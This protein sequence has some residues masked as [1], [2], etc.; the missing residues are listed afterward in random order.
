MKLVIFLVGSKVHLTIL[1]SPSISPGTKQDDHSLATQG[2][3]IILTIGGLPGMR[4]QP[5]RH[6]YSVLATV[7]PIGTYSQSTTEVYISHKPTKKD[8]CQSWDGI[9][10]MLAEGNGTW[11]LKW[12][13]VA[14]LKSTHH[15]TGFEHVYQNKIY[16]IT[17]SK[18]QDSCIFFLP[19]YKSK[20]KPL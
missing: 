11:C 19:Q 4:P 1:T 15:N 6:Q 3:L 10:K 9:L 13:A 18:L 7:E 12:Q 17:I 2:S 5:F 16:N 20:I 14:L 8:I